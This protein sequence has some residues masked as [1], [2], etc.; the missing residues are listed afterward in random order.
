LAQ[1]LARYGVLQRE[2]IQKTPERDGV[3]VDYG[4][5]A[6]APA[7]EWQE[8]W[9]HTERLLG[10]LQ[11]VVA[12]DGARLVVAVI[13]SRD[14]AYPQWWQEVVA[15]YP[16]MQSQRWDLDAPQRRIEAW[17]AEHGV[18]TITLAPAFR[19]AAARG[20]EPLH[21]HHDGHWTAAGHRLAAAVL[22]DFLEQHRL[23]PARQ[24]GARNEVH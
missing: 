1:A 14:Q 7:P 16:R 9:Q 22:K 17:G 4:V 13:G 8:A 2:A 5:Y 11:Q 18:P 3:P 23:V 21:Y 19:E 12:A 24:Q 10:R 20:G 15:A 6:S